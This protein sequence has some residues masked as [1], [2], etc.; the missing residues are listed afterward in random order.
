[1]LERKSVRSLLCLVVVLSLSATATMGA[2]I[3]F[4]SSLEYDRAVGDEHMPGDDAIKAFLEDLGHTVTYF[5]D[6]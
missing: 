6:D 4:I 5:D 3:L 1:M 2:D